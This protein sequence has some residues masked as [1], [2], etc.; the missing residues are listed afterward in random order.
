MRIKAL[1]AQNVF[2]V[3]RK[4]IKRAQR[5][6]IVFLMFFFVM[7]D[8]I[9]KIDKEREREKERKALYFQKNDLNLETKK[10]KKLYSTFS[11][12]LFKQELF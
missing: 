5:K 3:S 4:M 1:I 9:T 12:T 11:Q 6:E 2:S 7:I 8:N 10:C